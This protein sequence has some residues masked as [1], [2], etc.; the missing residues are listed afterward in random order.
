MDV[1]Y[2]QKRINFLERAMSVVLEK[3]QLRGL[4]LLHRATKEE[5]E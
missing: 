5:T 2:L 1:V 3:H 4:H